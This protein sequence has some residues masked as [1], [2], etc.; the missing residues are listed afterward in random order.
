MQIN[1]AIG[2]DQYSDLENLCKDRPLETSEVFTQNSFYG[3]DKVIKRYAGVDLKYKL[4][5]IIPHG[6]TFSSNFSNDAEKKS[7]LPV[8]L[9]YPE[10]RTNSYRTDTK[11]VVINSASPFCYLPELFQSNYERKG[12]VFFPAHSTHHIHVDN[13]YEKL[14]ERL[15]SLS[16]TYSPI[17][18][19]LY[20]KDYLDGYGKLFIDRGYKVISAGHINDDKFLYR[21]YDICRHFEFA[22]SNAIGSSLFY[23]AFAGCKTFIIPDL[24]PTYQAESEILSRDHPN[25]PQSIENEI[26]TEFDITK[27]ED[28]KSVLL[29]K[30]LNTK[31]RI[32]PFSMKLLIIFSEFVYKFVLF[33]R[34]IKVWKIG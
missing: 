33:Y 1:A 10:Y 5:F 21:F 6:I 12:L 22:A 3:I 27:I 28:D 30:Y 17:V 9:S 34:K 25:T 23:S 8:I 11:K 7:K 16:V 13:D 15:D 14:L 32:S 24:L 26:L 2:L 29:E 18:V 31:A 4:K 19:C 20:W